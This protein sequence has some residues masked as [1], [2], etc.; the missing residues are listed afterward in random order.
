MSN[1][2]RR[3]FLEFASGGVAL[4][5]LVGCS[6][7]SSPAST[8]AEPV[9]QGSQN[10][11]PQASALSAEV[12]DVQIKMVARPVT[13]E[14]ESGVTTDVWSY[15]GEVID[16][17]PATLETSGS[18]LGPTIHLW[19]GQRVRVEFVNEIEQESIIHWHGLIVP[20]DQDGQPR[21]A[22]E[23]GGS[24]AY[25]FTVANRPGT[26]WYHPHPHHYTGEQVYRGLSGLIIIHDA[27]AP[28][29]VIDLPVVLQDRTLS[30]SGELQY[31]ASRHDQ[32]AGFV[33]RDLVTNGVKNAS[34]GLDRRTYCLRVL[35]GS[36]SRTQHLKWSD[37][38][39]MV[40]IAT[41]GHALATPV[42]RSAV[43]LTPAQ[44]IDVWLDLSETDAR[45]ELKLMA[46]DTFVEEGGMGGMGMMGS[47]SFA[48]DHRTALSLSISDSTPQ[49][50]A[51]PIPSELER[52]D[53]DSAVNGDSP[54]AFVLSTSQGT[55][56]INGAQWEGES[57]TEQ[58]TV[59]LG[60]VE[61]WE[62]EN[63]SPMAHP[64]HI[65]AEPFQVVERSWIDGEEPES[66]AE[67]AP[68]II[69]E[70]LHDTVHVWPGQKVKVAVPFTVHSGTFLYHC[71]I[72]EHEDAGMMRS[73][74]I[75]EA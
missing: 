69:D 42:E 27:D 53:V 20:D 36:N 35:N 16:G 54:K 48:L 19:P 40:V 71:H 29:D 64:M 50:V 45:T 4:G 26:Y 44:R 9:V 55:H 21:Y 38:R 70:G 31:V 52:V 6:S 65:H 72:L 46:A 24:Y 15:L 33:G 10:S 74:R 25:D 22:V 39:P 41:D 12:R 56:W 3:N 63:R 43:L 2:S 32:M 66:W 47:S 58:E 37:G 68:S 7:S 8:T 18:Y 62:F 14:I 51:P 61:I 17:D 13:A 75:I 1:I 57:V 11:T 73:F 49:S 60:T 23:P 59:A 67:I 30:E 34:Y 5:F 28:G